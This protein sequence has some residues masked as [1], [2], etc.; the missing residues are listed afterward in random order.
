MREP[1]TVI[2]LSGLIHT[3]VIFQEMR[4]GVAVYDLRAYPPGRK[5]TFPMSLLWSVGIIF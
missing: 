5:T 2:P 4:H 1:W 3:I